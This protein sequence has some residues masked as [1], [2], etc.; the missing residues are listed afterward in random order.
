VRGLRT[1]CANRVLRLTAGHRASNVTGAAATS[2]LD[3]RIT[4]TMVLLCASWG[5]QQVAIKLALID[6]GPF[7]QGATRCAIAA[8]A[9]VAWTL[10]RGRPL[11]FAAKARPTGL[12]LG[13]VF[14]VE[15]MLLYWGVSLTHAS[16]AGLFLY[17][18]P[19]FVVLIGWFL[20]PKERLG[21]FQLAGLV[22][23]FAG[24]V[25]AF[26]QKD[27]TVP[28]T[29]WLGDL[30][31]IASAI[32]W[33]ITTILIKASALREAPVE[34]VVL[35]QLVFGGI[36]A[37]SAALIA[38]EGWQTPSLQTIASIA[39]QA[40]WVGTATYLIWFGLVA[41]YSANLLSAFTFLTPLFGIAAGHFVLGEP[42]TLG[43]AGACALV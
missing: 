34:E 28:A 37:G 11:T 21:G 13:V 5:L 32:L 9:V 27:G 42:V 4:A 18:T 15:Y 17:T 24:V 22:L 39:Y 38:G 35:Y 31:V 26:Q 3:A 14:G 40:L 33:A 36:V 23:A 2:H 25:L 20:L 29:A 1:R 16:R 12:L 41:R 6:M 7:T 30:M 8:A 43:F 19:F 10:L